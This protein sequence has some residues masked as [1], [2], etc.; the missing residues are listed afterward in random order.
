MIAK[1]LGIVGFLTITG[2]AYAQGRQV[3]GRL[4]GFQCM[5]LKVSDRQAMDPSFIVPLKAEPSASSSDIGRAAATV[6]VRSPLVERNGYIAA[7]LYNGRPGW[8]AATT[9]SAW[10]SPGGPAHECIPSRMSDGSIGL[11]F[12]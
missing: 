10:H 9:V 11:T 7:I 12:R 8:I 6:F 1:V 2:H 4:D 5:S 3:V